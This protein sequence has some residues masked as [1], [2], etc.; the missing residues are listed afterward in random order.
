MHK[1][2]SP[3]MRTRDGG[4]Y[5]RCR[6]TG[7]AQKGCGNNVSMAKVDAAVN[8]IIAETF[9]TPVMLRTLVKGNDWQ[10][11]IDAVAL[12]LRQLPSRGLSRAE[13]QAER[14][15]LWAEED[16]LKALPVEDDRWTL[17]P[18]GEFY[19][20]LYEALNVP[21]RGAWLV[22]H[23]FRVYASKTEVTVRQG[24]VSATLPL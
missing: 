10:P 15:R 9:H 21:E 16:R 3:N 22:T 24:D 17:T 1:N 19:D 4:A 12:E 23:G 2:A 11:E 20:E 13:E 7:P 6:G 5:Y 18:T 14:E 8:R